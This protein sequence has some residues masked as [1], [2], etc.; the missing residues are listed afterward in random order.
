MKAPKNRTKVLRVACGMCKATQDSLNAKCTQCGHPLYSNMD[1]PEL[2]QI[3]AWV[4][5]AEEGLQKIENEEKTKSNPYLHYDAVREALRELRAHAYLPGMTE[6]LAAAR[7]V[8]LPYQVRLMENTTKANIVF[9]VVLTL[10]AAI[11][12]LLGWPSIVSTLML[13]PALVW[14]G[15]TLRTVGKL[16]KTKAE[17]KA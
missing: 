7:K 10:F 15:L 12:I 5:A 16:K 1:E 3:R 11:P 13:M 6:Y 17:L 8:L 2:Q 4:N 9:C 14:L